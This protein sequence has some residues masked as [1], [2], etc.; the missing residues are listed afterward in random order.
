MQLVAN[1]L[2]GGSANELTNDR[3]LACAEIRWSAGSVLRLLIDKLADQIVQ[4]LLPFQK[5][6]KQ[7][8]LHLGPLPLGQSTHS[9]GPNFSNWAQSDHD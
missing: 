4:S 6:T 1:L 7:A 8:F 5:L 2:I 3:K 9:P